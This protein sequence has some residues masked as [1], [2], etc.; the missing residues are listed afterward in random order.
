[1]CH[2]LSISCCAISIPSKAL[3]FLFISRNEWFL[4]L[5]RVSQRS[6]IQICSLF[7]HIVF[8]VLGSLMVS[9]SFSILL[10]FLPLSGGLNMFS[11]MSIE[12]W[13][14]KYTSP[15]IGIVLRKEM[16]LGRIN[17]SSKVGNSN[18]KG[19]MYYQMPCL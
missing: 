11:D 10:I 12:E 4:F 6:D 14:Q 5:F 15:D 8:F 19:I 16:A 7:S 1:M 18:T 13:K 9:L 17:V 2:P 3:G